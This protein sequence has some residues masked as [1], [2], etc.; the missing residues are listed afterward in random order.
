M[1]SADFDESYKSQNNGQVYVEIP[2]TY[3]LSY[4]AFSIAVGDK[5]PNYGI[6]VNSAYYKEVRDYFSPFSAHPLIKALQNA[7]DANGNAAFFS[8]CTDSYTYY[9]DAAGELQMQ[10]RYKNFANR[11]SFG[12]DI[13][14]WQ[15]F[16]KATSFRKFY[17]THKGLYKDIADNASPGIGFP[18]A[19]EWLEGNLDGKV[20]DYRFILSPLTASFY[21][22]KDLTGNKYSESLLFGHS[23]DKSSFKNISESAARSLYLSSYFVAV[24]KNYLAANK[25]S[26][27][28]AIT[29]VFDDFDTWA[30]MGKDAFNLSDGYAL[31]SEYMAQSMFLLYIREF[32]KDDFATVKFFRERYMKQR[33]FKEFAKFY[34]T[35]EKLY[36]TKGT[37]K[38]LEKSINILLEELKK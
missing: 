3:E 19:W 35:I 11:A 6:N 9:F 20:N 27:G 23:F 36:D 12:E 28:A 15:D 38:S 13:K 21:R 1:S 22:K 30:E 4:V 32:N 24:A 26:Y 7:L 10:L 34:T 33:G 18:K 25:T 5:A 31:F 8:I 14:L 37:S 29:K 16:A 17:E 2:E